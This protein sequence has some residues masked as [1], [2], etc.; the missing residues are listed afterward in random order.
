MTARSST[1]VRSQPLLA[2]FSLGFV[3]VTLASTFNPTFIFASSSNT[4][5]QTL[6]LRISKSVF[7]LGELVVVDGSSENLLTMESAF[8]FMRPRGV[9][10][11]LS[12]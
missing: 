4:D 2:I 1:H 6:A 12:K 10:T 9:S 8:S 7:D 11:S 5:D 3:W